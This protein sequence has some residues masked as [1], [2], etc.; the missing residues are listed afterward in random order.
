M[1]RI[2][3]GADEYVDAT[4]AEAEAHSARAGGENA[5]TSFSLLFTLPDEVTLE[6]RVYRITQEQMGEMMMFLVPVGAGKME[7]VFN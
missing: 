5:G 7:S 3:V 6:Q 2:E 1:F 4:L